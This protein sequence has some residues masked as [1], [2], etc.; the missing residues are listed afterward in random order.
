MSYA[1][2]FAGRL[3]S[4]VF[5]F[6]KAAFTEPPKVQDWKTA[7]EIDRMEK[8]GCDVVGMTGMPEAAL[9]REL[10]IEYAAITVV[11]NHAAGRGPGV[12]T[13]ELIEANLAVGIKR[14]RGL[15]EEALPMVVPSR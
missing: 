2:C 13:R 15:L 6:G 1:R 4:A 5:R 12:I 8:D 10:E 9:A 14:V 7:A 3:R 11:V